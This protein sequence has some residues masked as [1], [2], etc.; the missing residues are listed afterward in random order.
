MRA[1]TPPPVERRLVSPAAPAGL[2]DWQRLRSMRRLLPE[3]SVVSP[4]GTHTPP[5]PPQHAR[6]VSGPLQQLHAGASSAA[7]SGSQSHLGV[8]EGSR[9]SASAEPDSG[10][11]ARSHS[12][13]S[14]SASLPAPLAASATPSAQGPGPPPGV[15]GAAAA[16]PGLPSLW[17]SPGVLQPHAA[18]SAGEPPFGSLHAPPL[19]RA[20]SASERSHTSLA[21]VPPSPSCRVQPAGPSGDGHGPAGAHGAAHGLGRHSSFARRSS[22][23]GQHGG[24][25]TRG[26]FLRVR[27]AVPA[28]VLESV[29][30]LGSSGR[31]GQLPPGA[32]PE[33]A[34][35]SGDAA[36]PPHAA[37]AGFARTPSGSG[38]LQVG[39]PMLSSDVTDAS[40]RGSGGRPGLARGMSARRWQD[41]MPPPS[42]LPIPSPRGAR[43]DAE[44]DGDEAEPERPHR[45]SGLPVGTWAGARAAQP[46]GA[47]AGAAPATTST[48]H[49]SQLRVTSPPMSPTSP[50]TAS[51]LG[52]SP[53]DPSPRDASSGGGARPS[54]RVATRKRYLVF[55]PEPGE[56]GPGP[57]LSPA[58]VEE[59]DEVLRLM[60][61]APSA[62]VPVL[63][64]TAPLRHTCAAPLYL[65]ARTP[66]SVD[67]AGR[68]GARQAPRAERVCSPA[69]QPPAARR[70]PGVATERCA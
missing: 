48:T 69:A 67:G 50:G 33:E 63:H 16:Y 40:V 10:G 31:A 27:E 13:S 15:L 2:S 20:A 58:A 47:G 52:V 59:Q 70:A 22:R 65:C 19:S 4:T 38:V 9:A 43:G 3:G 12:R 35:V 61:C 1:A 39:S 28:A 6:G 30:G 57:W 26:S 14:L 53:R 64:C 29:L 8:A 5:P 46:A 68:S 34:S 62:T 49:G 23:P 17:G 44:G 11:G 25:A 37:L 36:P 41:A 42:L 51:E 55:A 21:A 54:F 60:G 7:A 18:L 24:G 66:G 56:G 45:M 32:I